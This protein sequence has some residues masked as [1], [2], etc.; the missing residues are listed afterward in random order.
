MSLLAIDM[1]SSSCKAVAFSAEGATLAHATC[2]YSSSSPHPSWAET[3]AEKFW[4]ALQ[5]V[6]RSIAAEATRD[7]VE[8]LAL[9]S[10]GETF[11]PVDSQQRPVARGSRSATFGHGYRCLQHVSN[12]RPRLRILRTSSAAV[13][14]ARYYTSSTYIPSNATDNVH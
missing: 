9:S 3:E 10:H 2:S 12:S 11:V 6:T 7:P 5:T 4:Q 13:I 14:S 8:V 1:G